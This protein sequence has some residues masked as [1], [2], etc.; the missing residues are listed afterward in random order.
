MKAPARLDVGET[1][2]AG[3]DHP[4][5][6]HREVLGHAV[7]PDH[8]VEHLQHAQRLGLLR[9][10]V[11]PE[12]P[13][14][15]RVEAGVVE[16][17]ATVGM[18]DRREGLAPGTTKGGRRQRVVEAPERQRGDAKDEVLVPGD[19]LVEAGRRHAEVGR[20]PRERQRGDAVGI[21]DARRGLRDDVGAET[22]PRHLRA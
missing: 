7:A 17:E 11:R 2:Q 8:G 19:V 16:R 10:R 3:P 22:F 14:G 1:M 5:G 20:E 6:M 15:Q 13:L 21:D 4:G 12:R 18:G 9:V